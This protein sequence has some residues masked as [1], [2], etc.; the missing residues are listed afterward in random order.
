MQI[1]VAT[2]D[3]LQSG[4]PSEGA[5]Q[6]LSTDAAEANASDPKEEPEEEAKQ[7][8]P[9]PAVQEQ[10]AKKPAAGK[11]RAGGSRGRGRGGRGRGRGKKVS[12]KTA[13]KSFGRTLCLLCSFSDD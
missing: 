8:T 11:G 10:V 3:C 1:T 4:G 13:K 12:L 5:S 6:P 9:P 7:Q 2:P